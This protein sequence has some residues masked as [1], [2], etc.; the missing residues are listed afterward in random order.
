MVS[1]GNDQVLHV[2]DLSKVL[3]EMPFGFF[4]C[5]FSPLELFF[6]YLVVMVVVVLWQSLLFIL[7]S[8]IFFDHG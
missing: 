5:F 7:S 2:V 6:N 3:G 1:G 4:V 8:H